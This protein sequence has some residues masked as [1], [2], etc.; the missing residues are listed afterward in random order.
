M[1][2]SKTDKIVIVFAIIAL[3]FSFTARFEVP[4]TRL[5]GA[6]WNFGH[7]VAFYIW[8]YLCLRLFDPLKQLS[9]SA[10]YLTILFTTLVFGVLMEY[11][12]SY[13]GR[14]AEIGDL[15]SDICGSTLAYLFHSNKARQMN[16][17]LRD[18]LVFFIIL[19]ILI[20][21]RGIALVP[22][23]DYYTYQSF[24]VL[25]NPAS[26]FEISKF[27]PDRSVKV[28]KQHNSQQ[29]P[30]F[31]LRFSP[32]N[33]FSTL[34]IEFFPVSWEGHQNL[35]MKLDNHQEENIELTV[36]INDS[37]HRDNEGVYEDR[38]NGNFTLEPGLNTITIPVVDILMAPENRQMN[39][40]RIDAIGM[41]LSNL[42]QEKTLGLYSIALEK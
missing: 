9:P 1:T 35:V 16:L 36:R 3:I 8:T 18:C 22:I 4:S 29:Q 25:V 21:H 11:A 38:Y 33:E 42:E 40:A 7:I 24:P 20:L 34:M 14:S 5:F 30:F 32:R 23:N 37:A 2:L 15:M 17:L 13:I 19:F 27:E 41:F 6:V 31:N 10:Q 28:S 12:Q 39:L 26:S